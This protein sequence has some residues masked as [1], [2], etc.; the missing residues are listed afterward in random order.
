M[1]RYCHPRSSLCICLLTLGFLSA[2]VA[3]AVGTYAAPAQ[4]SPTL[5]EI[6]D[7]SQSSIALE[8]REGAEGE[9]RF[10]IIATGEENAAIVE[11]PEPP[12]HRP[13]GAEPEHRVG[14]AKGDQP[15]VVIEHVTVGLLQ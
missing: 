1:T 7:G 8:D 10:T 5:M 11:E 3:P 12:L 6:C 2:A 4:D 9:L 15:L 13:T 14:F